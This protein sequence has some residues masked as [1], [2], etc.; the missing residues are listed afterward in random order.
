[1]HDVRRPEE[2]PSFELCVPSPRSEATLAA[3]VERILVGLVRR[4]VSV[5]C[6]VEAAS[7]PTRTQYRPAPTGSTPVRKRHHDPDLGWVAG[8]ITVPGVRAELVDRLRGPPAGTST[9]GRLW[10]RP[11]SAPDG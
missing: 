1:M 4:T 5:E 8:S 10:V 3:R 2:P 11:V 7:R 9:V 6:R